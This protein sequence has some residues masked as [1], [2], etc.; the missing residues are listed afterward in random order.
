MHALQPLD[1]SCFK[2]FKAALCACINSW[3]LTHHGGGA[4][5]EFCCG[6]VNITAVSVFCWRRRSANFIHCEPC[7]CWRISRECHH[8]FLTLPRH[9]LR[10][11]IEETATNP[12]IDYSWSWFMT[13]IKDINSMAYKARKKTHA[14]TRE[15]GGRRNWRQRRKNAKRIQFYKR[16]TRRQ[17]WITKSSKENSM[18]RHSRAKIVQ[19]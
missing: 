14:E 3:T 8:I 16:W 18:M 7:P 1:V 13:S 12:T 6:H 15:L 5:K 11:I 4:R 17:W 19:L 10:T 2:S 9:A